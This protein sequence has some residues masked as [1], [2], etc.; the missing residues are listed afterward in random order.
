MK[1]NYHRSLEGMHATLGASKYAWIRYDDDHF[2]E[3]YKAML[4][5]QHGTEL[6][7]LAEQLIRMKIRLPRNHQ[8][9]NMHVNDAIGFKMDP[10]VI[11][12]YSPNAFGTADAISFDEHKNFLRVHDLKTG[13]H[14]AKFDQLY[15]YAALF[16]LEYG[17]KPGDIKTEFRIYQNDEIVIDDN[18]NTDII[19]H[20]MDR[21]VHFDQMINNM[22]NE[23]AGWMQ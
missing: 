12:F 1:F 10:E 23:E 8:T 18:D 5:A 13:V 16:C 22:K 9:L 7:A 6:H 17:Y 14:P 15:I 20:I 3:V 2:V 11:L 4:A 19:A 21:M